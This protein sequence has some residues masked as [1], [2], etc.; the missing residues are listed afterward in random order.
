V[1]GVSASPAFEKS[2]SDTIALAG[3]LSDPSNRA[4][5]A[6]VLV[7]AAV[8]RLWALTFGFPHVLAHP[9]E[10]RV[11][12]TAVEFLSG[13]LNPGFFNYPTLFMYASG[14][15]D[16]AYCAAGVVTAR[17][18]S[19]AA[20]AASWPREWEPFFFL[21]RLLS[22]TAGVTTVYLV[23]RIAGGYLDRTAGLAAAFFLAVA[24][25]HVRDSHF[26][27]TDVS[28]TALLIG[29]VFLL[30]RAHEAGTMRRFAAAGFVGGLAVS[31][32][33]NAAL[34]AIPVIV[35]QALAWFERS[36]SRRPDWRV[37]AYAA[38]MIAGF[39]LG[40]PYALI[41][42]VRVWTDASSEAT[43]LAAGHG[44]FLDVGWRHHLAV[45]LW[46]GLTWPLLFA[47]LGGAIWVAVREPARAALLFAFPVVYY[48][49]AGRGNTVFARYMI[50]V[51]PFLCIGAGYLVA[52]S[53]E[54][55]GRRVGQRPARVAVV[56]ALAIGAPSLIKS[57]Q[58]DAVL[59]RTDSRV[60]ASRWLL[61]H[62]PEHASIYLSGSRYGRPEL[63]PHGMGPAYEIATFDDHL[64][65]F[66]V[67]ARDLP[68]GPDFIVMQESPLILYSAMPAGVRALLNRYDL[69]QTFRA[70]DISEPRVFDQ[71]DAFF[72]PLDGFARVGRPG[73]N[74]YV[75]ARRG[76]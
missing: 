41:D 52:R 62:I 49:A 10:V 8:L 15:V 26:A 69:R 70:L 65:R 66:R 35:S 7:V 21:A 37:P 48:I 54:W 36:R 43:H 40:T 4:V 64:E 46:H 18:D 31:T 32:K 75:Y 13:D 16:L 68:A 67:G 1:T 56:V 63:A 28:M 73:P 25:L 22:A 51:I 3:R 38:A 58:M 14:G 47:S 19:I 39:V 72:L 45:T 42:P 12:H 76:M 30:L 55:A 29:S 5:I 44:I 23:W 24:F 17:F 71:Q 59:A 57:I 20:C 2:D 34:L 53:A 27:V 61:E 6:L 60:L 9:D 33:Y 11:V 74:V 50:P